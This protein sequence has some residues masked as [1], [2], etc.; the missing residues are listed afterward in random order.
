MTAI[1]PMPPLV[2]GPVPWLGAGRKLLRAPTEFFRDARD[3]HGDTY[4]VDAFGQRLFCV[5][6]AEGVR[7]LYAV[8][9]HEASFGLATYELVFRHKLPPELLEGRRNRPHDL[10][11]NPDVATYLDRLEDSVSLQLD[12]LGDAGRFEIFALARRLGYRLGLACWAGA[13]AAAPPRLDRLIRAFD[14]L[15]SADSFVRPHTLFWSRATGR[16]AE[17]RAMRAIEGEMEAVLAERRARGAAPDDFLARIEASWSDVDDRHERAVGVARDLMMIQMGAQSN[18]YAA[19]AWTLVQ[20]LAHPPLL[21]RVLEGDD[22]LLERSALEAIRVAQRSI[23]LRKV[24]VPLRVDDGRRAYTLEPGVLLATM[25]SVTNVSAARDLHRFDPD[26]YQGRR[27]VDR[28]DL[29]ARELVSTFGHGRH[30]CP[31]QRFSLHAIRI[32]LRRLLD[33]YALE[34]EYREARPSARQLGAVARADAPCRVR[35]RR[36]DAAAARRTQVGSQPPSPAP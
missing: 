21:A 33:R 12:E 5:F 18:L 17:R 3:R 16:F 9:E 15:D 24:L 19:M 25:L 1:E 11:K 31:A 27:L 13:E 14:R 36:R 29:A 28:D 22:E 23:T 34:P 4:A 7:A 20:L 10:F 2:S 35:Y 8:P 32:A 6:S 30:S 26:H